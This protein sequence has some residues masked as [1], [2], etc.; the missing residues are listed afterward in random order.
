MEVHLNL[1]NKEQKVQQILVYNGIKPEQVEEIG[2][3]NVLA[4]SGITG[5]AGETITEEPR[6][7]IRRIETYLRT[8]RY[9]IN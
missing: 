4:I 1:A 9:K 7:S 3:G 2:A 8:G 6:N 5:E